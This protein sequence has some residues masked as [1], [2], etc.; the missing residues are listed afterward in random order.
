[1]RYIYILV[2]L[3]CFPLQALA[4][5]DAKIDCG[6]VG[7][8]LTNDTEALNTCL[9]FGSDI[10]IPTGTYLVDAVTGLSVISNSHIKLAK[11][12][13]LQAIANDSPIYQIFKVE[14]VHDVIIEGGNLRGDR[15]TH[16]Y[17][18][19]PGV[20]H[21][22]GN[23]I[24]VLASSNVT[25]QNMNMT[26][27]TGDCILLTGSN[28]P[29]AG[30]HPSEN[31]R[32]LDNQLDMARR[33]NISV[34]VARNVFIERNTITNAG[35]TD[36]TGNLGTAPMTGIDIEGGSCPSN[37][38][39]KG[40]IFQ[41]NIAGSIWSYNG[42]IVNISDNIA[43]T[44]IG[45]QNSANVSISGNILNGTSPTTAGITKST[46]AVT[47]SDVPGTM[48]SIGSKY[49]I[50]TRTT[51]DFTTI[52][53]SNNDAGTVFI[54]TGTGPLGAGDSVIRITENI[55]IKNNM[56]S[57]FGS[58][59]SMMGGTSNI[60]IS[61]N[62]FT[63]A[64]LNGIV[65]YADGV[66]ISSNR[67]S[68]TPIG[69]KLVQGSE[70]LIKN[71]VINNISGRAIYALAGHFTLFNNCIGSSTNANSVVD[72]VGNTMIMENNIIHDIMGTSAVR[73]GATA[74]GTVMNNLFLGSTFSS[75]VMKVPM[76]V[77][78]SGNR[79]IP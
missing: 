47:A 72:V 52:G 40:N 10:I 63:N 3:L 13:N 28:N 37:I 69:I 77:H 12:A 19:L 57:G 65:N 50:N 5:K 54:A 30:Y 34:V 33:N 17:T 74:S 38:S 14:N 53:A 16:T 46:D 70:V 73:M 51:L 9:A 8:G 75:N 60:D 56:I 55:S 31:I 2:I 79:I 39:I 4:L 15:L 43:D 48:L 22:F 25:I 45:F 59:V 76:T 27:A 36:A 41:G 18:G 64:K 1:L 7:N 66:S 6:A 78:R 44:S 26:D 35:V 21:E 61:G 58:S 24:V 67:I 49:L 32:I 62:V 29:Q 71:N 11:D 68:S 42:N 23:L 20:T